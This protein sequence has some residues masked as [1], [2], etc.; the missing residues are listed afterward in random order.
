MKSESILCLCESWFTEGPEPGERGAAVVAGHVASLSGPGVFYRLRDLQPG[1]VIRIR[2]RDGEV[3]R[4]QARSMIVVPKT[5]FPTKRDAAA[6]S[7]AHH[8]Q[9]DAGCVN[10]TAP[11]Q[12]N[13][14]RFSARGRLAGSD[15]GGEV[16]RQ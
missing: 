3:V 15:S 6:D 8:L 16:G 5:A 9:R 1:D 4:Y 13:R 10:R 14:F 7:P 2:L 11:R 12:P